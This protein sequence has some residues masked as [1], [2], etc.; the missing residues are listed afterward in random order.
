MAKILYNKKNE[1]ELNN[2]NYMINRQ[3]NRN[4]IIKKYSDKKII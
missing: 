1:K 3:Y 4:N 2:E